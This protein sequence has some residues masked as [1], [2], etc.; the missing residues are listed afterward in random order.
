MTIS[1]HYLH[2]LY[3]PSSESYDTFLRTLTVSYAHTT[4]RLPYAA[5]P[6]CFFLYSIAP[7]YQTCIICTDF[8]TLNR[9]P[10]L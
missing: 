1:Y 10:T 5:V 3:F 2:F 4:A 6:K 7:L 8:Y 9:Y